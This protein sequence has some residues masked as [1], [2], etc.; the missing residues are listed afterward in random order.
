L[1]IRGKKNLT[2]QQGL[3]QETLHLKRNPGFSKRETLLGQIYYLCIRGKKNLTSQQGLPQETLHL[4]RNPGFSKRETLLG[5]IYYLCIR[6]KKKSYVPARSSAG[7]P[8]FKKSR[9]LEKRNP[10]WTDI[11]FVHSW[12]KKILSPSKIF[13]RRP[14]I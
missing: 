7:D 11:L 6:G 2:S 4:K 9:V 5:Q 13:R 14:C 8:A 3:P 12:Q 10:A 1:C